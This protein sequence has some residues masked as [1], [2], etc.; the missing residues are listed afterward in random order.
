MAIAFC[1]G[2]A[3]AGAIAQGMVSVPSDDPEM[4][5]AQVKAR[6]TVPKFC[7]VLERP[8]PNEAAF[9]LKVALALWR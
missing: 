6:G 7:R 2:L 9:A 1:S 3:A 8:G 5:Q 4:A